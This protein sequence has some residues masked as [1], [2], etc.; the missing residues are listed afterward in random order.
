MRLELPVGRPG[1]PGIVS[2][3]AGHGI[4]GGAGVLAVIVAGGI[5]GIGVA[6]GILIF[7]RSDILV[8]AGVACAVALFALTLRVIAGC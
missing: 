6:V 8:V 1:V 3:I 7:L 2:C 4:P 5:H